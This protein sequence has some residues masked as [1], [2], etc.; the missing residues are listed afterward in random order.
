MEDDDLERLHD[1]LREPH[2]RRWWNETLDLDGV[3]A[4]YRP[5]IAGL[6]ATRMFIAGEGDSPL[7][8]SHHGFY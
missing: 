8:L 6:D 2:V 5:R 1:W 4:K 3:R 7:A